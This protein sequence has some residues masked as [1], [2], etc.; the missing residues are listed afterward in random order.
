MNMKDQV[1]TVKLETPFEYEDKTYEEIT[2]DFGKLTGS[3]AMAIE[4]EL[5]AVN[6]TVT[7]PLGDGEYL[8]MVAARASG[9]AEDT[10]TAMPIRH[11][12]AILQAVRMFLL[13]PGNVETELRTKLEKMTGAD[14]QAIEAE[15]EKERRRVFVPSQDSYFLRKMAARAGGIKEEDIKK[16]PMGAYMELV[17]Q[18]RDFLTKSASAKSKA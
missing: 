8:R 1:V 7:F 2:M 5:E 9:I 4:E 16:L 18:V 12:V 3:D 13:L 15:L 14:Y 11:Y 6:H 17:R 10:F